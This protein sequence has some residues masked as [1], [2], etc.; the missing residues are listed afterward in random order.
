MKEDYE[1]NIIKI[2]RSY[3]LYT[4]KK[5]WKEILLNFDLNNIEEKN[6]FFFSKMLRDKKLLNNV[7]TF[8]NKLNIIKNCEIN[9]RVLLTSFLIT[10]F[11]SDLLGTEKERNQLDKEILNWSKK[12]N[13]LLVELTGEKIYHNILKLINFMN[14]YN[15]FFNEW[16][17]FDKDRTIQNI[18]I[19]Y[20]HKRE[21]IKY[22]EDSTKDTDK[23]DEVLQYLNNELKLLESNILIIDKNFDIEYLEN[24]Y[25]EIFNNIKNGITEIMNKIEINF[26]KSYLDLLIKES[27][28]D[29]YQIILDLINETNDRILLLT[30]DKYKNSISKKINSFDYLN[31]ILQKDWSD[32][33]INYLDFIIDTVIIYCPPEDDEGNIE[34]KNLINTLFD[35]EFNVGISSLLVEINNKI[36]YIYSKIS[37]L[38]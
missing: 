27:N 4:L 20:Y 6:F 34:W 31:I 29:N 2:Q 25:V 32:D 37:N 22:V 38:I 13:Q 33:I 26:K 14:C 5:R 19:S 11:H 28:E 7:N 30:P 1:K 24:N 3:R 23:N 35:K 9:Q 36:D 8:L 10:N 17:N 12:L 21:H 16:K 15:M 18:I